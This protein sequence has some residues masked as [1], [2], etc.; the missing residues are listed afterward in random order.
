MYTVEENTLGDTL[1]AAMSAIDIAVWDILGRHLG[2]PVHD[3]LGG[4][5]SDRLRLYTSYR[6]GDIPRTAAAY[7]R[8]TE[9]LVALG[10]TA[11][12]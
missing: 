12:K 9:E 11:G 4:R 8:R 3:L 5:V 2:V 6:W 10:A 1:Y 7:R